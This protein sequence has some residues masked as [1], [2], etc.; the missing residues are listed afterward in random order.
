MLPKEMDNFFSSNVHLQKLPNHL[1]QYIVDQDY[2]KYTSVDQAVW[3]YV[4]K[5]NLDYLPKVIFGDYLQ[6]LNK[7]GITI[8]KIPDLYGKYIFGDYCTGKL[9]TIYKSDN[10]LVFDDI[11]KRTF[12]DGK[13]RMFISSF[14]EDLNKSSI[15]ASVLQTIKEYEKGKYKW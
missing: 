7:A 15:E 12:K 5:K 10:E 6:G 14:G 2:S 13:S 1:L 11:G 4:M 3:R 8:E 9:W